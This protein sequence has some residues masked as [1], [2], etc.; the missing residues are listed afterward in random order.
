MASFD[1]E[2]FH[3]LAADLYSGPKH[4]DHPV[5]GSVTLKVEDKFAAAAR[6]VQPQIANIAEIAA[7]HSQPGYSSATGAALTDVPNQNVSCAQALASGGNL[8][9]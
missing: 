5:N 8:M 9:Q 4:I 2:R 6:H 3:L 7:Q 1:L